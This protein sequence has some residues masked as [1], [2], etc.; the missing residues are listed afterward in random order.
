M[1]STSERRL[2][3][4]KAGYI[5]EGMLQIVICLLLAA[6]L[7]LL[8]LPDESPDGQVKPA[9]AVQTASAGT[10]QT[11]SADTVQAVSADTAQASGSTVQTASAGT[12]DESVLPVLSSSSSDTAIRNHAQESEDPVKADA[13]EDMSSESVS[14]TA[15]SE[16]TSEE[17]NIPVWET[18]DT[19]IEY[20]WVCENASLFPG[21]KIS[22]AKGNADLIHFMYNYGRGKVP[23]VENTGLTDEELAGGVPFL[24]QWDD[25]WGYETYGDTPMGYSGCGPTSLAMV[26]VGLTGR[27]DVTPYTV[28]QYAAENGY[29]VTG[30]G[31]SWGLFTAGCE[32][33][34][35]RSYG[36][37]NDETRI[38]E[39]LAAGHPVIIS[40]RAGMFTNGGHIMVLA[41]VDDS[42]RFI[43]HDPNN[44]TYSGQT[45]AYS[46][47]ADQIVELWAFEKDEEAVAQ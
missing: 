44:R 24:Y 6:I 22:L 35:L 40:V 15:G 29:Y 5:S 13:S 14:V 37:E 28:A 26:I 21:G 30:E 9:A 12:E 39:A 7:T 4:K 31:T 11:D 45:F 20:A 16:E 3:S 41:G 36:V 8:I 34:G 32:N 47:I 10:V 17:E 1:K 46:D 19:D 2:N 25:R 27:R 42:G 38:K 33:W 18:Y 43:L 23:A